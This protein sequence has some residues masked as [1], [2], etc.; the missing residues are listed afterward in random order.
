MTFPELLIQQFN[1]RRSRYAL[2][3]ERRVRCRARHRGA[4]SLA[5][6]TPAGPAHGLNLTMA[7]RL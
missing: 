2:S 6:G 1:A 5:D 3:P 7:R 4:T